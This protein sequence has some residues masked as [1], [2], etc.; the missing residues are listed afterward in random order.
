LLRSFNEA[1]LAEHPGESDLEARIASYELAAKMQTR[2][3]KRSTLVVSR[4]T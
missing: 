1:H 4:S 2:R 3:R